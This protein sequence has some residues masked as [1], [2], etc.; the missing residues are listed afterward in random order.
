MEE[1]EKKV[2]F[3]VSKN[4]EVVYCRGKTYLDWM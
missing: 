3:L 2:T 4:K 1:M